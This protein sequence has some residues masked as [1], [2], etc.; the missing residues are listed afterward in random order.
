MNFLGMSVV[1]IRK[2]M[3]EDVEELAQLSITTFYDAFAKDNTPENMDMHLKMY[4]SAEQL[5]TELQDDLSTFLL[6]YSDQELVGY[7]KINEHPSPDEDASLEAPV[8]LARIYTLQKMIGKG[9]GKALMQA[10]IDFAKAKQKKT[11]W[12]GV[13][14]SNEMAI[15]FYK[16]WGFE[17]YGD[18]VFVVGTDPQVDWLMKKAL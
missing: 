13:W 11:I 1:T 8:E 10:T 14:Q 16:R 2:A 3:L 12:L 4:Y 7:V 6:A 18:H 15:A 9:I 17:I 5:S